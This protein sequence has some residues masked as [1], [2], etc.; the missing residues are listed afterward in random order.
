M[1]ADL[2]SRTVPGPAKDWLSLGDVLTHLGDISDGTLQSWIADGRFPAG[3]PFGR[4]KKWP[5]HDIT[6]FYMGKEREARIGRK[7]AEDAA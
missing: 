6:W 5:W 2:T 4:E 1:A 7:Q 3:I